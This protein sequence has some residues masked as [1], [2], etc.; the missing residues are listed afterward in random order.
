MNIIVLWFFAVYSMKN[1]GGITSYIKKWKHHLLG[2]LTLFALFMS[3]TD[4]E[5][6]VLSDEANLISVSH[7]LFENKQPLI[8]T[9]GYY[10]NGI[11]HALTQKNPKRP[12]QYSTILACLHSIFGYNYKFAFYLNNFL[13]LSFIVAVFVFTT[14]I[15]N[16]PLA[17]LAVLMATAQPAIALTATSAGFDFFSLCLLFFLFVGVFS[18]VKS[19]D[20][21]RLMLCFLLWAPLAYARYEYI[22]FASTLLF[23]AMTKNIERA[24]S[25]FKNNTK[26][27]VGVL[28]LIMPRFYQLVLTSSK[29][30]ERGA[31]K[32]FSPEF[33]GGNL[34]EYL[35]AITSYSDAPFNLAITAIW[36]VAL[37]LALSRLVLIKE[38]VNRN[39]LMGLLFIGLIHGLYLCHYFGKASHPAGYRLF[40]LPTFS[41]TILSVFALTKV[42]KTWIRALLAIAFAGTLAAGS[43]VSRD[44]FLA[45]SPLSRSTNRL[46]EWLDKNR[47]NRH[48]LIV[49][50]RPG[51]YTIQGFSAV[52]FNYVDRNSKKIAGWIKDKRYSGIIFFQQV[53]KENGRPIKNSSIP[54][55]FSPVLVNEFHYNNRSN[56]RVSILQGEEMQVNSID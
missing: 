31:L 16:P 9:E 52:N 2:L 36:V 4:N 26:L 35:E 48:S 45:I 33:L 11:F 7:S 54:D 18:H 15:A 53:S 24:K 22:L 56:L 51:H 14:K 23:F 32:T 30:A 3:K 5:F 21:E 25:F 27:I 8:Q 40:L 13:L 1:Q 50:Q 20:D 42:S 49:A 12:I 6:R 37:T 39:Y 34:L 10:K 44:P 47:Q 41:I 55:N 38:R 43:T 19:Q 17:W 28:I 46:T 29:H